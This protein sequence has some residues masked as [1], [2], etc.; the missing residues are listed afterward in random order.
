MLKLTNISKTFPGVKALSEVSFTLNKGEVH[1]LCGENG[2]GKSTLMNILS[3]NLQ[4]DEGGEIR[5]NNLKITIQ[6]FNHARSLG[7]AIVYQERSLIDTLS[8]AENIFANR[9]PKNRWGFIDFERLFTDTKA[10]LNQL[11]LG[12]LNPNTLVSELS[13]AEKQ[14][15]EIGKALSQNPEILILDEPTA[16]ITEKE[17]QTLF[18][19]IKTLKSKGTGII[20]ISHR[21]AEIFEIADVVTVLKDGKHQITEPVSDSSPEQL[22][23]RM[24]GRDIVMLEGKSHAKM[25]IVLEVQNLS[26]GIFHDCSFQ[27]KK[28]EIVALAGLVGAGRSEVARAI[29]GI[30]KKSAGTIKLNGEI[31]DLKH[32]A[33]AISKGIGYVPEDRKSQGLFMEMSVKE[34][35]L[36]GVFSKSDAVSEQEQTNIAQHYKE[37]LRIQTPS[38]DQTIGLLSG[39]N[40]QK[41]VLA[42]WLHLNPK[43]LMVDEPTH[44]IDVGA[45]FE[46][47]QLLRKLAEKGTAIILI[48]SELPEVLIMSDRI[49]VMHLGKIKGELSKEEATEENILAL[50]S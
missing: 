36:A 33:N 42:R 22:I 44:G 11:D 34:N 18:N 4:P 25:D 43:V 27:V 5:L 19:I 20:Y 28:G 41:C 23:K 6:N 48:S 37:E 15:V 3:G 17:T 35:I 8:V 16:S 13:P 24:V 14:M 9:S 39:G 46:I 47:Y 38:I 32:P 29:F 49:L 45:K 40:Q 10:I 1:A 2:A 30:D 7:I 31:L 50:A 12:F 21:L 26:G